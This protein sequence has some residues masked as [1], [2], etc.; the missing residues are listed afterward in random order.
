[1]V[2]YDAIKHSVSIGEVL[3]KYGYHV[4]HRESYRIPCMIHG[5]TGFNLSVTEREN[6]FHC[7]TCNASGSV[8]DLVATLDKIS[9]KEAAYKLSTDYNLTPAQTS[10]AIARAT[11]SKVERWKELQKYP[12]E[13]QL[14]D[15]AELEE[16]YRGFSRKTI[17]HWGLK[18]VPIR[19]IKVMGFA[20]GE[21]PLDQ[22]GSISNTVPS[23]VLIPLHNIH[24]GV[25]SYSVRKDMGEPKYWNASGFSKSS[26]FGSYKNAQN[27]I[28]AGYA[29][30]VEG[31][32]DCIGLYERDIK[33]CVALMGSS[34]TETQAHQL[35]ALTSNVM[36]MMDGDEV[37]RKAA[38]EIKK[39]W[40]SVFDIG[41][42][43]IPMGKDPDELTDE[44]LTNLLQK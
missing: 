32:M 27:I 17:N 38:K 30:I 14:P 29:I 21:D 33:N 6:L 4:P 10:A 8:I 26:L 31:Q 12:S 25:C 1:M 16:G 35:L 36:L 43:E 44:E 37:G 15:T 40:S 11:T 7:F 42:I 9:I 19:V 22:Y 24:G 28:D 39:K 18:R 41:V 2:S 34:M 20:P 3:R 13:V 23:G 5:G